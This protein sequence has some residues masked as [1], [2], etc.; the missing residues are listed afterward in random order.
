MSDLDT[1]RVP[2][3]L[4]LL[5]EAL[6]SRAAASQPSAGAALLDLSQLARLS[7]PVRGVL[8]LSDDK[9]FDEIDVVGTRHFQLAEARQAVDAALA[10]LEPLSSRDEIEVAVDHLSA[11]LNIVYFNAGLSFGI[12]L[13]DLKSV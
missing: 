1:P 11:V 4:R 7:I 2:A 9:L 10:R 3:L 6:E 13:A 8:P 12:T 5:A